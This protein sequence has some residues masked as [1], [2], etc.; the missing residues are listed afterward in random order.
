MLLAMQANFRAKF[1]RENE[2]SRAAK[3]NNH[4]SFNVRLFQVIQFLKKI[5]SFFH[6]HF[7]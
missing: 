4:K 2:Q 6:F 7:A 3:V 5:K 1:N